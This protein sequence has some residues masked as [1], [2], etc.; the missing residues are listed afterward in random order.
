LA[1]SGS[2][3]DLSLPSFL[4]NRVKQCTMEKK[5]NSNNHTNSM[6]QHSSTVAASVVVFVLLIILTIAT[7]VLSGMNISSM[8]ALLIAVAIATIKASLVA[9]FFMHL[10]YEDIIFRVFFVFAIFALAGI[11][12]LTFSDYAFRS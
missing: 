3:L 5:M 2:Y 12:L 11:F 10:H 6:D 4:L 8:G 7:V 9:L 1:L